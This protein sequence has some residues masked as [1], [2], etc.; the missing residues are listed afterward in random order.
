MK[1]MRDMLLAFFLFGGSFIILLVVSQNVGPT[2]PLFPIQRIDESLIL[3]TKYS[4]DAKIEYYQSLIQKRFLDISSVVKTNHRDILVS[5][6]LRYS[7]TVGRAV[8]LA[9]ASDTRKIQLKLDLEQ[10]KKM[11][12]NIV[13]NYKSN[14]L[15]Q[16]YIEDDINYINT[17]E[18]KL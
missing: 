17:Y 18:A 11:L 7:T 12:Q 9:L 14:D 15:R 1:S 6:S 3:F 4:P 16:K 2:S 8:E 10:Q 13:N 5:V